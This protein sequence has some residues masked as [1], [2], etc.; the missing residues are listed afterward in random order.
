MVLSSAGA[1]TFTL[2]YNIT[3]DY[4]LTIQQNEENTPTAGFN[5][6]CPYTATVTGGTASNGYAYTVTISSL[7][8][9]L[10]ADVEKR[11]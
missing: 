8:D 1:Y 6:S 10:M 2:V 7:S 4:L 11:R 5:T 9:V 3:S